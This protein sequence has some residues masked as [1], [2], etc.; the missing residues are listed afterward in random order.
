VIYYGSFLGYFGGCVDYGKGLLAARVPE[1]ADRIALLDWNEGVE[2][3]GPSTVFNAHIFTDG[4]GGRLSV[5]LQEPFWLEANVLLSVLMVLHVFW[6]Y[7]LNRIAIKMLRG[8]S[9]S[10]AGKAVYEGHSD[11]EE[12]EG[13]DKHGMAIKKR[14]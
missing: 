4:P 14:K 9:G 10:H 12:G 3:V 1:V 8:Q 5:R 11:S 13:D 6:F 7:L 2:G